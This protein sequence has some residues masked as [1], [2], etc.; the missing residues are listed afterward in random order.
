MESDESVS[1]RDKRSNL[2]VLEFHGKL[3]KPIHR[4][5]GCGYMYDPRTGDKIRESDIVDISKHNTWNATR[6]KS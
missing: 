1:V 4:C 3:V 6:I 2:V 5:L